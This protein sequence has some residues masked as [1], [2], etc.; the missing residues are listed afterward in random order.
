MEKTVVVVDDEPGIRDTLADFF[1]VFDHFK[2]Y[3]VSSGSEALTLLSKVDADL[4]VSD[5]RMPQGDGIFLISQLKDKIEKGLKFVFMTGYSDLTRN[6]ALKLGA[7]EI[8]YKPF[9]INAMNDYVLE[10]LAKKN[11]T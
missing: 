11:A 10:L 3:R 2:T 6:E 7:N 8:F 1:E 5:I 9:D 4:I